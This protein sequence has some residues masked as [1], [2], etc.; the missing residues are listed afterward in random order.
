MGSC[1]LVIFIKPLPLSSLS[2][3]GAL[4]ASA[5]RFLAKP[6]KLFVVLDSLVAITAR[7]FA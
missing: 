2:M 7:I 5:V 6:S 4:V 1:P 3:I